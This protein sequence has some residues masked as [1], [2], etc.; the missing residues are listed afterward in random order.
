M[1]A[2]KMVISR[3]IQG[4]KIHVYIYVSVRLVLHMFHDAITVTLLITTISVLKMHNFQTT[5][6]HSYLKSKGKRTLTSLQSG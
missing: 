2:P 4:A 3:H 6:I 5:K 1:I